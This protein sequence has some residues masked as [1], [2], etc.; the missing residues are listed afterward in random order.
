MVCP[1]E[2]V[3]HLINMSVWETS[4]VNATDA[5][6]YYYCNCRSCCIFHLEVLLWLYLDTYNALF[7]TP[8][9]G[10]RLVVP[11]PT[12]C[13]RS[14]RQDSQPLAEGS[15]LHDSRPA[16]YR[17]TCVSPV[18]TCVPCGLTAPPF[19]SHPVCVH[20]RLLFFLYQY[21]E[22]LDTS[23]KLVRWT[24]SFQLRQ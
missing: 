13:R 20:S 4:T 5:I 7:V 1:L 8:G 15:A 18:S 21:K 12:L 24:A 22:I 10:G 19:F 2:G 6:D 3:N 16:A 23:L 9:G 11:C 14:L 17:R